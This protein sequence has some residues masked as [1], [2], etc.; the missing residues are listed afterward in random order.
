[1]LEEGQGGKKALYLRPL[2]YHLS[3]NMSLTL[4]YGTRLLTKESALFNEIYEVEA[5]ISKFRSTSENLQD[6]FPVLRYLRNPFK[7]V[8]SYARDIGDR[9][10]AFNYQL[11]DELAHRISQ[12]TDKPCIQGN[13]MRK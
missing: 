2:I 3:I 11:L 5:A 9:R 10:K 6:F 12:N 13:V 1:L 4:N 8:S 7:K